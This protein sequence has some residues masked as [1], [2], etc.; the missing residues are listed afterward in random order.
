MSTR[1][2]YVKGPNAG[3]HTSMR[4][5]TSSSGAQYK[6]RIFTGGKSGAILDA[7]SEAIITEVHSTYTHDVKIL[8][9]D[10]LTKLGVDFGSETRNRTSA[11]TKDHTNQSEGSDSP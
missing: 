2:R 3:E 11:G 1:I 5:L 6:S 9:K 8:L 4:V 7:A 10:E